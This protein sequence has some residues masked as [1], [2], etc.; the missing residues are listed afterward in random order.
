MCVW[1]CACVHRYAEYMYE[2]VFIGVHICV[3]TC[4]H[5]SFIVE[6]EGQLG[7]CSSGAT[8]LVC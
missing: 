7:Y 2:H 6:A 4:A 1:I 3:C 8:H 5:M